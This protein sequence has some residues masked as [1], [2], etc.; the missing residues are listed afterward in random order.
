MKI[1][2]IVGSAR[3]KHT[4]EST[5][6]LLRELKLYENTIFEIISLSDYDI[7]TCKGCKLCIDKGEEFCPLVDQR[8]EILLKMRNANG[9]VFASPNYSFHISGSMKVFL[10]RCAFIFHR[11]EFFG[12]SF[13]SIVAQGIFGGNTIIKYFNFIGNAMGFNVTQGSCVKTLEPITEKRHKRN[14]TILKKQAKKFFN[15]L[16]MN[17]FPIPSYLDLMVFRLSRTSMKKMLTKEYKDYNHYKEKGW[18]ESDFFY[19]TNLNPI[20]KLFGKLFDFIGSKVS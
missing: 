5:K 12:K 20:K 4:Y 17:A 19:P 9:V 10:D 18:F 16:K 11:P 8:D 15:N 1:L 13:T 3:K 14:E 7:K 2:A 6:K